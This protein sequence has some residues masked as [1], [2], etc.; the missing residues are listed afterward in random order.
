MIVVYIVTS[1]LVLRRLEGLAGA[2]AGMGEGRL[3]PPLPENRTDEIGQLVSTFNLMVRQIESRDNEK[4]ELS[5]SLRRQSTQRGELLKRVITAQED[6]RARLARELHDELGQSLGG[7]ALSTEALDRL[8]STDP[9]RARLH[10]EQIRA[11]IG[12]TTDQMYDLILD[13]RPSALDDLGLVVAL[14]SY[15][16]RVLN[17]RNVAL[18]LNADKL[19]ERLP[20]T[21]ETTLYRIFQ[22][23]I[24]NVLRHS[25]AKQVRIELGRQDGIF[26]GMIVDDGIGFDLTTIQMDGTET[27]GLGLLECGNES[28]NV[29]GSWTLNPGLDR[30][31]A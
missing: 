1:Q 10:L 31:H 12:A 2:I 26:E 30:A 24:T 29:V 17:S 4:R 20:P 14:R 16:D 13:L 27:R 18:E 23:A 3:P 9:E 8:I 25:G 5:D 19:T 28:V 21:I 11:L 6:E 7:L 22:E 15:A